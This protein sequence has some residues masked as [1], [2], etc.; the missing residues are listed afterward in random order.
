MTYLWDGPNWTFPLLEIVSQEIEKIGVDEMGLSIYPNQIEIIT[1]EQMLDAY[2]SVGMPVMYNHWSFGKIFARDKHR[3]DKGMQGL[4]YEIVINSNPCISYLMEDNTMTMQ[5]LT[6]SHAGIGHNFFFKNNNLF[7]TWTDASSIIDYLIFAKKYILDCEN[8]YGYKEVEEFLDCCHSL[9]QYGVNKY[10]KPGK[11][12]I[13]AEK[14][15]E[16]NRRES[17]Q[18]EINVLYDSLIKKSV[19]TIDEN[20]PKEPEEN[21]LYFCEKYSPDLPEWKRECIRIVRKVSQYFYPQ[22]QTKVMNEGCATY[23]HHRIMNRLHD[24]KLMTDGSMLEFMMSHTNVVSQPNFDSKYYSGINPYA[25]GFAMMCDIERICKNPTKEDLQWFPTFAGCNDHMNIL[26][27]AWENYRDE[28]FIRQFLS[29]KVIRDFKLFH[30]VNDLRNKDLE[31]AFI[32]NDNGYDNIRNSLADNYE[33]NNTIPRI[34]VTKMDL[35]SRALHLTYYQYNG[36]DLKNGYV[37]GKKIKKLWNDYPIT[38]W[39]DHGRCITTSQ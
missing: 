33:I 5:A 3:Y 13:I 1:S 6:I 36:R 18:A 4:A 25:L 11:L 31:V 17:S 37:M 28:S 16:K 9:Q 21:I 19:S 2:S 15:R 26:R 23:V 20:F 8:K 35:K 30:V 24:K 12:S 10:K 39:D 7:K 14:E 27:H 34:E 32:H 29:P 38:I 22:I